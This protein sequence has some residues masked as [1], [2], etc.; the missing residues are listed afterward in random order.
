[1]SG[2]NVFSADRKYR[3][4]LW[5]EILQAHR[6]LF[7]GV[8]GREELYCQF[9]GL[10][11]SIADEGSGLETGQKSTSVAPN[12]AAPQQVVRRHGSAKPVV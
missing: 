11:P 4:T 6:G 3:Y 7:D 1:M 5:R 9:I 8:T 10:N 12:S 2:I